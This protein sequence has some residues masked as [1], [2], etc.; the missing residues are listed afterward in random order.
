MGLLNTT[1]MSAQNEKKKYLRC[2]KEFLCR[3]NV[4]GAMD[5]ID[6]DAF[7]M[8]LVFPIANE[9]FRDEYWRYKSADHY[10]RNKD[11]YENPANYEIH[12]IF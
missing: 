5:H 7:M 4:P 10:L 1:T 8:E 12:P 9:Q 6:D 3:V 11:F 2:V